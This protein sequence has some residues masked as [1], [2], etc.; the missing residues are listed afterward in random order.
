MRSRGEPAEDE[1]HRTDRARRDAR[2]DGPRDRQHT[3]ESCDADGLQEGTERRQLNGFEKEVTKS[4][5]GILAR[6]MRGALRRCWRRRAATAGKSHGHVPGQVHR[7][8]S[9]KFQV[10]GRRIAGESGDR[11][12]AGLWRDR[13][14][15]TGPYVR[16]TVSTPVVLYGAREEAAR[17]AVGA[18]DPR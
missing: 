9:G 5:A 8:V 7:H 11:R 4:R 6:D 14:K 1:P 15:S 10:S 3:R 17:S 2:T 12:F 18:D 16:T 13:R